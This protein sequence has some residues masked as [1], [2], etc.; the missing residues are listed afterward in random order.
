MRQLTGL[1]PRELAHVGRLHR[2]LRLLDSEDHQL[3]TVAVEAGFTDQA[4]M[5]HALKRL[6]GAT[7]RRLREERGDPGSW[8]GDRVLRGVTDLVTAG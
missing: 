2:V 3:A 5:T 6:T 7:P 8:S 4:H 1:S